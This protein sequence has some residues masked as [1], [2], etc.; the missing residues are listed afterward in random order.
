VS[1]LASLA[2]V[3]RR[4]P[5]A[6]SEYLDVQDS[7]GLLSRLVHLAS[8]FDEMVTTSSLVDARAFVQAGAGTE[9]DPTAVWGL[10]TCVATGECDALW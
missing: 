10:E 8:D 7:D 6:F 9:Y 5:H 3:V 2:P 1:F 4:H